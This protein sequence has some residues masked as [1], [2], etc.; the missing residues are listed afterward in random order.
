MKKTLKRIN[1]LMEIG[2]ITNYAIA[3][4]M[5]Q[6]YYIEPSVTYDLDIVVHIP[7]DE[8]TLTPLTKIY[9][10]AAQKGYS[11]EKEHIIIEGIPVQFLLP[12]DELVKEAL[13]NSDKIR[14]FDENTFILKPEYLMVIMLQTGRL[15]DKERLAR[16]FAEADYD[17]NK[18]LDLVKRFNLFEVYKK[19]I[20][21]KNG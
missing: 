19:L 13:E 8:D 2:I 15:T 5:A 9:E 1:E 12:Y 18:F 16:F 14:L 6:F 17:K 21:V 10:W 4:G 7:G 3:G 20:E 11:S